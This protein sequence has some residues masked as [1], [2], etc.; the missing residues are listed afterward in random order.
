MLSLIFFFS[1]GPFLTLKF[2]KI[3]VVIS[4]F[5]KSQKF[6]QLFQL[7]FES[8][9][10]ENFFVIHILIVDSTFQLFGYEYIAVQGIIFEILKQNFNCGDYYY[11]AGEFD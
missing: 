2:P 4:N 6:V 11:G 5:V 10:M 9:C 8:F 7:L 3:P 1:F